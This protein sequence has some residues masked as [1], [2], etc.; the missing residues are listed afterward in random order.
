MDKVYGTYCNRQGDNKNISNNYANNYKLNQLRQDTVSFSG[1][2]S[3][4][5][6]T[7]DGKIS[8]GDKAKNFVKGLISPITNM[9]SSPKNFLIGAGMIAGGVAL[10]VA[11]GGAIAPLFVAAGVTGG[12]IQLSKG[13]Y[14]ASN[15]T[16]DAEAVAAWQGMGAGTTAIGLSV[17][18]AKSALKGAG[19]E[20]EGLNPFSATVECFKQSPKALSKTVNMFTSGEAAANLGLKSNKTV[21]AETE[22]P[23]T[24]TNKEPEVKQEPKVETEVKQQTEQPK[25][26][27]E[28]IQQEALKRIEHEAQAKQKAELAQKEYNRQFEENLSNKSAKESASVFEAEAPIDKVEYSD[29]YVETYSNGCKKTVYKNG[30]TS[31]EYPDGYK[32]STDGTY[33]YTTQPDGKGGSYWKKT[34]NGNVIEE[35][36]PDGKQIKH[37]NGEVYESH[38]TQYGTS[39]LDKII[40]Q[41]GKTVYDKSIAADGTTINR[42]YGHE[43][44]KHIGSYRNMGKRKM[45]IFDKNGNFMRSI[46]TN[47]EGMMSDSD[48]RFLVNLGWKGGP[49]IY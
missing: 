35:Y 16:T 42:Y 24:E 34:K 38:K 39:E 46:E 28:E 29:H 27:S 9:F 40:G 11:T 13:I 47:S 25:A 7:D 4:D 48:T 49:D 8:T 43:G 45:E 44:V 1:N 31:Y 20:T 37:I 17:A 41:N 36:T 23:K 19:V 12:A 15:A 22:Q 6:S 2:K 5:Y 32:Y 21:K 10:T 3:F 33:E 14:N 30:Q 26:T 18:G